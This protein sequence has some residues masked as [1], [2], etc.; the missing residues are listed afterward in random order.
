MQVRDLRD[1]GRL[2]NEAPFQCSPI[3]LFTPEVLRTFLCEMKMVSRNTYSVAFLFVLTFHTAILFAEEDASQRGPFINTWLV[4]GTFDNDGNDSGFERDWI[5]EKNT[6]PSEGSKAGVHTWS[7][8]DDRLFSRN[9]DDY[10]DLF[11]YF[12]VKLG[13]PVAAKVAYAH[14]YV[15]SA[16]TQKAQLRVGADN[17]FKAWLNG[18]R[19]ASSTESTPYRDSVKAEVELQQG[20]NRLLL[21]IANRQDG[22][23]GFYARLCKLDGT[24]VPGLTF[25]VN[26]G[27]KLAVSTKRM[28]AAKTSAMPAAFREWP[29]VGASVFRATGNTQVVVDSLHEPRIAM[30][31][32][33]FCAHG[34]RRPTA[35][36]ME[37]DGRHSAKRLDS[38]SEWHHP[39]H[40]Q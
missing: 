13:Q 5:D 18:K 7:Y 9:Y 37:A 25:S 30:A 21:K 39:R 4:A 40:R 29:Y 35:V 24:Q 34:S 16:A 14:V 32:L 31:S 28:A 11:S 12:K 15:H 6:A 20:W 27:G 19:V 1:N 38:R 17:Q 8:F 10:Q 33:R 23:F 2:P 26:C 22:R 36:H 3:L